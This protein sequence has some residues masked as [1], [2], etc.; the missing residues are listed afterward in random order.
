VNRQSKLIDINELPIIANKRNIN[1]FGISRVGIVA[2]ILTSHQEHVGLIVLA[3]WV[4]WWI[5]FDL[6]IYI[7]I[8]FGTIHVPF[9]APFTH[10]EYTTNNHSINF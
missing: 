9:S 3:H 4:L 8:Y 7:Y 1:E 6:Y 5:F 10:S 2:N